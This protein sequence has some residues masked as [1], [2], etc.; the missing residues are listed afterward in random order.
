MTD[1]PKKTLTL[2][3]KRVIKRSDIPAGKLTKTGSKP[4]ATKA[5]GKPKKSRTNPAPKKPEISPSEKRAR[6]LYTRLN[7]FEVW[8]TYKPLA[9]GIEKAIFKICNDEQIAGASKKVVQKVLSRHTRR[10]V[11]RANLARGGRRYHL[12][13]GEG[14]EITEDQKILA[15]EQLKVTNDSK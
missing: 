14:G 15:A 7:E 10:E 4:P 11:Y 8:R 3:R 5:P 12:D 6:E 2:K 13:S 9:I 1:T